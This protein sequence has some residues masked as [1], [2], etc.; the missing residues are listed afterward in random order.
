MTDETSTDTVKG[1]GEADDDEVVS[2]DIVNLAPAMPGWFA[3][4]SASPRELALYPIA[5]FAVVEVT[6]ADGTTY[7]IMRPFAASVDGELEDALDFPNFLCLSGPGMD[8]R[9]VASEARDK[10]EKEKPQI[11]NPFA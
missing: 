3:C 2:T 1:N 9:V 7:R 5:A 11:I 4:Y 10:Q 6:H 8:P